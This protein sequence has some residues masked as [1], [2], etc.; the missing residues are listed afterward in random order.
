MSG[1]ETLAGVGLACNVFQL[2]SFTGEVCRACKTIYD[3]GSTASSGNQLEGTLESLVKTFEDINITAEEQL[4]ARSNLPQTL[5]LVKIAKECVDA[6]RALKIQ[7]D[8][9]N[10]QAAAAKGSLR[11]SLALGV[12]NVTGKGRKGV[13]NLERMVQAH[14]QVLET[15]L[16]GNI[17]C[18]SLPI[19]VYERLPRFL[20]P[21]EL[22]GPWNPTAAKQMPPSSASRL[23]SKSSSPA[24]S[25]SSKQSLKE[26]QP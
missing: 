6:A 14:R 9:H 26:R 24:Y 22:I 11:A 4:T 15:R 23:A 3:S 21:A 17:W 13:E 25:T 16:L 8:K 5:E 2:L 18:D 20:I 1:L 10:K 7:V 19:Y 12:R